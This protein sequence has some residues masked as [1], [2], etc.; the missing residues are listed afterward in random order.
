[1]CVVCVLK[2]KCTVIFIQQKL[3]YRQERDC[4][5]THRVKVHLSLTPAERKDTKTLPLQQ[6]PA[7]QNGPKGQ[8]H[9]A[10]YM[11]QFILQEGYVC[12][13]VCMQYCTVYTQMALTTLKMQ[14]HTILKQT[15]LSVPTWNPSHSS[16]CLPV[17]IPTG[18]SRAGTQS[19][20]HFHKPHPSRSLNAQ[21]WPEFLAWKKKQSQTLNVSAFSELAEERSTHSPQALT[22][23]LSSSP[24]TPWY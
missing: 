19:C 1:M 3:P 21:I 15:S 6:T 8:L 9:P 7:G 17:V 13:C 2:C 20:S 16:V 22:S 14:F 23:L 24:S 4:W 18:I 11:C 10:S 12:V 5:Y